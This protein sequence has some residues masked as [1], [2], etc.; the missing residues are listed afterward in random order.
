MHGTA[1]E[2]GVIVWVMSIPR[3]SIVLPTYNRAY[4]L[5]S[6]MRSILEQSYRDFELIIVDDGSTDNTEELVCSMKDDRI[7][8]V[9]HDHNQ[10]VAVGRNTG[11]ARARGEF[12]AFQD[13]DDLWL[14]EKLQRQVALLEVAEKNVGVVYGVLEKIMKDGRRVVVPGDDVKQREGNIF[15]EVLRG[16]FITTQVAIVRT[17]L[18]RRIG[19]FDPDLVWLED[20]D[21]WIRY[22]KNTS[23]VFDPVVYVRAKV[24]KDSLTTNRAHRLDSR[25]KTYDKH[26]SVFCAYPHIR[27]KI[28]A[29]LV[30]GFLFTG[31]FARA[32]MYAR[33]GVVQ[34]RSV[35]CGALYV[36]S[37]L[38]KGVWVWAAKVRSIFVR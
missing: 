13:S 5:E 35:V 14:P 16:N 23:A 38:P 21:F 30:K 33:E 8:Y 24:M 17:E 22:M 6:S 4:I 12:L 27:R 3:V 19:S 28:L 26:R 15:E 18:V 29:Q 32:R 31:E 2:S 10:G 37:F 34:A 25:A 11:V 36:W 20:W 1:T 9:R 7:V